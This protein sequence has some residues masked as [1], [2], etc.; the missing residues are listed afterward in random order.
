MADIFQE[1]D[2]EVRRERL[3]QL[4]DKYSNYVVALALVIVASVGGWRAYQ[5]WE[6]KRAA[7]AGASFEQAVALATQDKAAEAQAAFGKIAAE[8]TSGYRMLARL[9]EAAL[10]ARTD[11]AAAVRDYDAIANDTGAT[12]IIRDLARL[13]AAMLLVDTAPAQEIASRVEP[14]ATAG[15]AFRHTARELMALAA[16]R[17]GDS[18]GVRRWIDM[19]IADAESPAGV[20]ARAEML[21]ALAGGESKG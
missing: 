16:W 6:A 20:R 13:R 1:I 17:A 4:W 14:I 19:I 2:E 18:A 3:K 11:R 12:S 7:E 10:L 21:T 15:H 5:W 9:R 8:G